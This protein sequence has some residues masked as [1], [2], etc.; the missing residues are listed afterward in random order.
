MRQDRITATS[1][2]RGASRQTR[3]GAGEAGQCL[4]TLNNYLIYAVMIIKSIYHTDSEAQSQYIPFRDHKKA[5]S[6]RGAAICCHLENLP[7]YQIQL[8]VVKDTS[9]FL[10]EQKVQT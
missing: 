8:T 9:F 4:L 3:G 10:F 5:V 1:G 7:E 2:Q 6:A